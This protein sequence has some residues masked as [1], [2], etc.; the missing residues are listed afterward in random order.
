MDTL[1]GTIKFGL[2]KLTFD[3]RDFSHHKKFGTL[4]A[5][6]LPM[7]DFT[8]YDAFQYTIAWGD[9][10]GKIAVKFNTTILQIQMANPAIVDVNKIKVGQVITIPAIEMKIL[11]QTDLDFCT[12]F[13]TVELQKAIFGIDVDPYYQFA[14]IKQNMGEYK[15]YGANLRNACNSV[16]QYGSLNARNA[17]YTHATG[18]PTDK[19]RDFLANW[20]NYPQ[21]LDLFASKEKDL[22]Y[23]TLDGTY[24]TFDNIRS[25]LWMHM[26]ERRAVT[27]GFFWHDAWTEVAG[28]IIPNVMP[29]DAEGGGHDMAIIGQK[30]INGVLY[31]VFQ[32]SWGPNAGD[33]GVY[34][35]PRSIVDLCFN[36]GYGAYTFS[37]IQKSSSGLGNFFAGLLNL[38]MKKNA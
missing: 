21:M 27:F 17:P 12:A 9:T 5:A 23:F 19:D 8:I 7:Q 37:K 16:I 2:E 33:K 20:A 22:A 24:D 29:N 28:G 32:Q 14:K 26:Q 11:N 25:T 1:K 15:S 3:A 38:F 10:L 35:F 36:E 4:G 31:L 18:L 34:Y 6:Q 13:S 30:T